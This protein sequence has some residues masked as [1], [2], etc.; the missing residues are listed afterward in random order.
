M[1]LLLDIEFAYQVRIIWALI[2]RQIEAYSQK[3]WVFCFSP[4]T[5]CASRLPVRKGN[6]RTIER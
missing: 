6:I 1:R 2:L 3:E 5:T 4:V